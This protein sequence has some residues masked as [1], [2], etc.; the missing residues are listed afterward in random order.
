MS[1]MTT[2]P[3][4]VLNPPS[5]KSMLEPG[6]QGEGVCNEPEHKN[7][8]QRG[9]DKLVQGEEGFE[10]YVRAHPVRS[11]LIATGVG[12]AL[13]VFLGRRR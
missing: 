11:V 7:L 12:V 13:G 6:M 9:K 3:N 8:L 10:N 2:T 1:A 4:D 5:R